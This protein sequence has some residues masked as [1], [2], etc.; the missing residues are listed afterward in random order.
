MNLHPLLIADGIVRRG[1]RYADRLWIPLWNSKL[2]QRAQQEPVTFHRDLGL[3]VDRA[4]RYFEL[5]A[6]IEFSSLLVLWPL[7]RDGLEPRL[8]FLKPALHQYRMRFNNPDLRL[9]DASYEPTAHEVAGLA[10]IHPNH[11]INEIMERCL[12]ADQLAIGTSILDE[13]AGLEDHGFYGTTHIVLGCLILQRFSTIDRARIDALMERGIASMN[14]RQHIDDVG[15]LFAERIVFLQWAGRHK[16]VDSA[17]MWRLAR[18]QRP[19]G[20]WRSKRSIWPHLSGQHTSCLALAALIQ[21]RSSKKLAY[22]AGEST[23]CKNIVSGS[24]GETAEESGGA[25]VEGD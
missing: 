13:L 14:R 17:W 12:Y 19:D 15:D 8:H 11:P 24:I 3:A 10:R 21:Y 23:S 2:R 7:F 5:L 9:L 4:I 16:D 20:G 25:R 6:G 18:A 1:R 22:F